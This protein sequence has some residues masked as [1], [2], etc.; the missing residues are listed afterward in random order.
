MKKWKVYGVVTGSKYM[1]EFEAESASEAE[2]KA[3]DSEAAGVSL[4]WA[5]AGEC[6]DAAIEKVIVEESA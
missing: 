2:A 3:F 1:G 5:C 4:C 6:E